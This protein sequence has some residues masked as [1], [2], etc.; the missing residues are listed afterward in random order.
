MKDLAK[1]Q[2]EMRQRMNRE[3]NA[4]VEKEQRSVGPEKQRQENEADVVANDVE[5]LQKRIIALEAENRQLKV[6]I[7]SLCR[8]KTG[9]VERA[10]SPDEQRREQQ[11]NYFKYSNARRW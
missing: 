6:E 10:K 5:K 9:Y 11:H 7:E 3:T 4:K 8:Q 2:R 1:Q